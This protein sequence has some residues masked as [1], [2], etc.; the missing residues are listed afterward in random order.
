VTQ[1]MK[2]RDRFIEETLA[3]VQGLPTLKPTPKQVEPPKAFAPE[4]PAPKQVEPPEAFAR[5]QPAKPRQVEPPKAFAP[6]QPAKPKDKLLEREE[7][8]KRLE[9]F[10]ATQNRFQHEHE[11][12]Y[13]A[14]MM[15]V[16]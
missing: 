5:E 12:Y 9:E 15:K 4:Q 10:K 13:N 11:E 2:D 7:I 16:R 8:R 1:W 6:Q 3:F 14:A